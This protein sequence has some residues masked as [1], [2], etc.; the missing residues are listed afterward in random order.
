MKD[1]DNTEDDIW[2]LVGRGDSIM[3]GRLALHIKSKLDRAHEDIADL[4]DRL[5][6]AQ[7][8]INTYEMRERGGH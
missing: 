1:E 7:R 6:D 4:E 3:L 5:K 2:T 8:T